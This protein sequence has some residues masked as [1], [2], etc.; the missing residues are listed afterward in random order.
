MAE[1]PQPEIPQE[2]RELALQNID[3]R[4]RLVA[5]SWMRPERRGR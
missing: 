3:K 4:A 2:M 5:S 1:N